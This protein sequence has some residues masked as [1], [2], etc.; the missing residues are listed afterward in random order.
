MRYI[1]DSADDKQI[2]EALAMGACGVTANPTMY[3][4]NHQNFHE[5]LKRYASRNLSF[6][7][8]EVMGS[9]LEEMRE[10]AKK[11]HA[12]HPDIVMKL[13]FS[14]EALI[15]CHELHEQGIRTAMT[16]IFTVAQ[17]NAAINAGADY[18][19][20]FIGRSDEYGLDGMELIAS[21]QKIA[22]QKKEGFSV[23]AASI[24]NLHQLEV[25]AKMGVDYAAI[26]FHLY[27]KSL[28]HP[29]TAQGA[30]DFEKDW[31]ALES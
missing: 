7:S 5:F 19:F 21:I 6:L 30:A 18:L 27:Q 20:P 23:V 31:S 14:K 9:T 17:A 28:Y 11:I 22:D 4:K 3:L 15:L 12:I 16:L 13:N 1:I 2:L 24:K 8:G 10:E 26:P 25:L 29:M